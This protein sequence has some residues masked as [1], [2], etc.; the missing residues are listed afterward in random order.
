MQNFG[1]ARNVVLPADWHGLIK[2]VLIAKGK[3]GK[4]N[5]INQSTT[6]SA[7]LSFL[8]IDENSRP[9]VTGCA[10]AG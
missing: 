10:K 6:R 2:R 5:Q 9:A 3:A 7:D 4:I 1:V 8:G